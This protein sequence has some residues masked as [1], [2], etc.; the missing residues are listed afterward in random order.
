MPVLGAGQLLSLTLKPMLHTAGA[1]TNLAFAILEA[2]FLS[3]QGFFVSLIFCFLNRE[4]LR[5]ARRHWERWRLHPAFCSRPSLHQGRPGQ[6]VRRYRIQSKQ[7]GELEMVVR[8]DRI[9]QEVS[10][11][12]V[13]VACVV[14]M[15]ETENFKELGYLEELDYF[16][17]LEDTEEMK[18]IQFI[19]NMGSIEDIDTDTEEASSQTTTAVVEAHCP[20]TPPPSVIY[21][22][23]KLPE[24]RRPGMHK[25]GGQS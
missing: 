15:E 12:T 24:L 3:L 2:I 18:D 19:E 13:A 20:Q 10:L 21:R 14:N 4:V 11:D 23:N 7:G 25:Q 8:E 9:E 1:T 5:A 17:E 6:R 16:V 22:V